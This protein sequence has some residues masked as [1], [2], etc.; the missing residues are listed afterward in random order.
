MDR[1]NPERLRR[2]SAGLHPQVLGP[3]LVTNR[4]PTGGCEACPRAWPAG[5]GFFPSSRPGPSRCPR[6]PATVSKRSPGANEACV[7]FPRARARQAPRA[8]A[9]RASV[10][11]GIVRKLAA[12]GQPRPRTQRPRR[13]RLPHHVP[14][15]R[16]RPQSPAAC[17]S[18]RSPYASARSSSS[19]TSRR[20][21]RTCSS[22]RTRSATA[23]GRSSAPECPSSAS[24]KTLT[25]PFR[26]LDD[27]ADPAPACTEPLAPGDGR[28]PRPSS[29]KSEPRC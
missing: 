9:P 1:E 5:A 7:V 3:V 24:C 11:C 19:P 4:C 29:P 13:H 20:R 28:E 18:S 8:R 2:A 10:D 22:A 27:R 21:G 12:E 25:G 17:R 6:K 16:Q 23:A 15:S 14:A 26:K